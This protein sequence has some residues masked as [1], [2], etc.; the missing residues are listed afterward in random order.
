VGYPILVLIISLFAI[1]SSLG[2]IER[3]VVVYPFPAPD[4]SL[5]LDSAPS[6]PSPFPE[7][8]PAPL[9]LE[10]AQSL[11]DLIIQRAPSLEAR[12]SKKI[13]GQDEAV[14]EVTNAILR[15]A[16]GINDPLTPVA[17]FLF[18][19]PSGVGKTELAR[20]LSIELYGNLS[21][22]VRIDM[23]EYTEAFTIS[24]L[25][26]APPG[27]LGHE[28]GGMLAN[29]L[30]SQ[31]Y[32]IVLLDEIEKAHP[33]ILKL[34]LHI[35]DAGHFTS[36]R[37][38]DIDCNKAI[39]ILTSNL[40]ATEIASL[41]VEG[42]SK[43]EILQSIE[44]YLMKQLSPELYNRLDCIVF[45]PLG[46]SIIE[47]LVRKV[48]DEL[49]ERIVKARGIEIF[50]EQTVVDYLKGYSI[51]PKLGARPLKRIVEKELATVLAQAIIDSACKNGDVLLCSYDAGS[52]VLET[53]LTSAP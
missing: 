39:F 52:V 51:D 25:I 6:F 4:S 1:T 19:G 8:K 40:A 43:Q 50:F 42:F 7:P 29:R 2:S 26:G 10:A 53:L 5:L 45:A 28:Q 32:S 46:D 36:A 16:A 48:L 20:Q 24:R 14:K 18:C 12:L 22:F 21:H 9:E 3:R 37:G 41:F 15:F 44:P 31:P 49:R 35:F 23:S 13:F 11:D 27:Y 34:F 17:S 30:L 33:A 38:Q 47:L